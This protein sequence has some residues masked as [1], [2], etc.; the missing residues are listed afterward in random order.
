MLTSVQVR[1]ELGTVILT[2]PVTTSLD[3][4]P[5]LIKDISGLDPVKA[6][7]STTSYSGKNGGLL[8][9]SRVGVRNILMKIGYRPDHLSNQTVQALRRELYSYF[10]PKGEVLLR[11]NDDNYNTVQIKGIVEDHITSLFS[12]DPE[13]SISIL[14]LD[15]Y[16]SGITPVY[17]SSFNKIPVSPAYYGTAETGFLFELFVNRPLSHVRL[18]NS[19]LNPNIGYTR[20]LIAGD[21]LQISTVRGSKF[22]RYSRNGV[23]TNDLEGL[24]DGG[25]SMVLDSRTSTFDVFVAGNSDIPYR[26]KFTPKFVGI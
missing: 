20:E 19:G 1:D 9:S 21:I 18:E 10:P 8:Q 16:F 22:V 26:L 6:D 12:K 17:L 23:W 14:C 2:L 25:L 7:I 4:A 13:V 11:F 15:P 3:D 5:Y 24:V